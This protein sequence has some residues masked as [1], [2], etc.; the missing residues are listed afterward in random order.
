M[1]K[2]QY[3]QYYEDRRQLEAEFAREHKVYEM[4]LK[5]RMRPSNICSALEASKEDAEFAAELDSLSLAL[6][7][8]NSS[9]NE[10]AQLQIPS[11][12]RLSL[13]NDAS[14]QL[15]WNLNTLAL[16]RGSCGIE[17]LTPP[18]TTRISPVHQ[19]D[20]DQLWNKPRS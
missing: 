10:Q 6:M 12:G 9:A 16:D 18:S 7:A 19:L 15:H 13:P 11:R 1:S 3:D 5:T 4:E 14:E 2:E 17:Y 20:K 8:S